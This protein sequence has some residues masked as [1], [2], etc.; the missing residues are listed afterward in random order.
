M[1]INKKQVNGVKVH[2]P[3]E[4]NMNSVKNIAVGTSDFSVTMKAEA[5]NQDYAVDIPTFSSDQEKLNEKRPETSKIHKK[6]RIR[7]GIKMLLMNQTYDVDDTNL[8]FYDR[9]IKTNNCSSL[10]L[11]QDMEDKDYWNS[12]YDN[13]ARNNSQDLKKMLRENRLKIKEK[14][15]EIDIIVL[16]ILIFLENNRPKPRN[17]SWRYSKVN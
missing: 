15:K 5:P 8:K 11:S 12:K 1:N 14:M 17:A 7:E 9:K 16:T 4:R 10:D 6:T 2:L 3:F 13:F